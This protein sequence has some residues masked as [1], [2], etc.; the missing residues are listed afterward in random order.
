MNQ[1]ILVGNLARDPEL[2][3]TQSDISVCTFS[4]ACNRRFTNAQGEREADFIPIVVWR[5]QAE[6]CYRYL[7]KGS[8]V[9][10]RGTIQVRSY[11]AQDGS[12]RYVTEVVADEVE[13]LTPRSESGSVGRDAPPPPFDAPDDMQSIE[14]DDLPF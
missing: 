3:K 13:F 11:D 2:R 6:N 4:V 8:R 9:A 14:D 1:A 12:K 5:A 7:K 10:V